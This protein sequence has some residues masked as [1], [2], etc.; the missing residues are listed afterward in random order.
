MLF[1]SALISFS[2]LASSVAAIGDLAFNLGVKTTS[3]ECKQASDFKQDFEKIA[4][5]SK[6]VRIYTTTDC[7]ELE[8]LAGA[9]Q[10]AGFKVFI[11]IWPTDTNNFNKEK[12]NL[13]NQL[14]KLS[15]DT[16]QAITVGSE[17]L[18]RKDLSASDLASAISDVKSIVGGLKDKDGKSFGSV[19]VG[20]ADSWNVLV[21]GANKD[22]ITASDIILSNAFSYW[23]GQTMNNASYSFFD[24][25]M[26]ALQ[27]IQTT[28]GSTDLNFWVGETGWA[29]DGSDF[30]SASP[31]T[32]NAARFWKEAICGI[33]AWGINVISF[34]AFDESWKPDTSDTLGTEKHWGVFNADRS[35]KYT[36]DC[37]FQ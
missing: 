25:I 33:R 29:T 19:P 24:D 2:L 12:D 27:V 3:G 16:I 20:T 14:P 22:V 34:E 31:T 11:G 9:A 5:F 6:V 26:Q 18:Y 37:S 30:Q 36:L 35:Q 32:S 1:K 28:K 15:V 21:D 10:D 23:Q 13:K 17:A 8:V 4:P 7:N